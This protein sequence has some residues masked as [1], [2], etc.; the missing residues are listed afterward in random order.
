[1]LI[2]AAVLGLVALLLRRSLWRAVMRGTLFL[3]LFTVGV[4]VAI[5]MA[6]PHWPWIVVATVLLV[7][8]GLTWSV[9]RWARAVHA[10]SIARAIWFGWQAVVDVWDARAVARTRRALP[11]RST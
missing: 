1:V 2:L 7:A 5:V 6:G 4:I 11:P 8:A 9:V 10:V 3:I